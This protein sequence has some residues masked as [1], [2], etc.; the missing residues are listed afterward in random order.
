MLSWKN[1]FSFIT[2]QRWFGS[3]RKR[4]QNSN[5]SDFM[6]IFGFWEHFDLLSPG[7]K[8]VHET[9]QEIRYWNDLIKFD[10]FHTVNQRYNEKCFYEIKYQSFK[11]YRAPD[12][13]ILSIS[14]GNKRLVGVEN[15]KYLR[16][17][18]ENQKY[19]RSEWIYWTIIGK[20]NRKC[21]RYKQI[22]I[23]KL[24]SFSVL[25]RVS[26]LTGLWTMDYILE[27]LDPLLQKTGPFWKSLGLILNRR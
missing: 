11:K 12:K 16:I 22:V 19:L 3:S 20:T 27:K 14:G 5:D 6:K 2:S 21:I 17:R 1:I 23:N 8:C 13:S 9:F 7:C 15:W 10:C 26:V 18:I 25:V 4:I 24:L